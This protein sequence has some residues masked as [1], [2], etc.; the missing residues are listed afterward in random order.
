MVGGTN[1]PGWSQE[2]LS[3]RWCR[4]GSGGEI[5]SAKRERGHWRRRPAPHRGRTGMRTPHA[6]ESS[7][8]WTGP[9]CCATRHAA[10][11]RADGSHAADHAG[12]GPLR[13]VIVKPVFCQIKQKRGFRPFLLRGMRK[14]LREWAL[15]CTTHNVRKLWAA[16]R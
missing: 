1:I 15:I 4:Q 10:R 12:P 16:L 8:A 11:G 3:D 7:A 13:Q 9:A 2:A 14:V 6:A 5:G